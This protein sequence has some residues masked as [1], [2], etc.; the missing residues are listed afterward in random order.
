MTSATLLSG[1]AAG[2]AGLG[3][4]RRRPNV[5][6]HVDE[7]CAIA[8]RVVFNTGRSSSTVTAQPP[9]RRRPWSS[10]ALP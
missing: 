4:A 8:S 10:S 2:G 3:C 9:R 7:H 5:A 1:Q 6:G